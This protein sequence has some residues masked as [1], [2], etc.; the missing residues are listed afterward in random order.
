Y[1]NSSFTF[2]K[3]ANQG[4][5]SRLSNLDLVGA[6]TKGVFHKPRL[7]AEKVGTELAPRCNI[8]AGNRLR[9][10]L[11]GHGPLATQLPRDPKLQ[12]LGA[13]Q[14]AQQNAQVV[15][16]FAMVGIERQDVADGLFGGFPV[17]AFLKQ[18]LTEQYARAEGGGVAGHDGLEGAAR[19]GKVFALRLAAGAE[20]AG[21]GGG[22]ASVFQ[23]LQEVFQIGVPG[24]L[25][26]LLRQAHPGGLEIEA[27]LEGGSPLHFGFEK[28]F[29]SAINFGQ[30]LA[31]A[32]AAQADLLAG[33]ILSARHVEEPQPALFGAAQVAALAQ[34]NA[35]FEQEFG[36]VG[37]LGKSLA[38]HG[39]RFVVRLVVALS[40]GQQVI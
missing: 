3:Y 40:D 9:R 2:T 37:E 10:E 22:E 35:F 28:S 33:E 8:H 18:D 23:F 6:T 26:V 39:Q 29:L 34:E 27:I 31:R 1:T 32:V 12:R 25:E 13:S 7:C 5:V 38:T 11:N 20:P 16:R 36:V 21:F 30:E 24:L 4:Q 14:S 15:F 17:A 19:G